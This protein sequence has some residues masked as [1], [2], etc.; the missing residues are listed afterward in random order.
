MVTNLWDGHRFDQGSVQSL[1]DT[2]P[3]PFDLG[4]GPAGLGAEVDGVAAGDEA[5][6][7]GAAAEVEVVAE[8]DEPR[9]SVT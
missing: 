7:E 2:V 1:E 5:L 6:L 3:E 8:L 4:A 9:E